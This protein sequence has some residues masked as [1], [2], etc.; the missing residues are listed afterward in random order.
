MGLEHLNHLVELFISPIR[1]QLAD[2][3]LNSG[4]A[5]VW[6]LYGRRRQ[7]RPWLTDVVENVDHLSGVACEGHCWRFWC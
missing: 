1:A 7:Q 4:L 3:P 2:A 5:D 6:H